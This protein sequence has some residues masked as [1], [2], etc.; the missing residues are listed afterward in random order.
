M[1]QLLLPTIIL[2]WFPLLHRRTSI[3]C[4]KALGRALSTARTRITAE[5]WQQGM[6]GAE[7]TPKHRAGEAE[8]AVKLHLPLPPCHPT[9][10]HHGWSGTNLRDTEAAAKH[11][12]QVSI[13]GLVGHA[14]HTGW[15]NKLLSTGTA[16]SQLWITPGWCTALPSS[17]SSSSQP[18]TAPVCPPHSHHQQWD[19]IWAIQHPELSGFYRRNENK[20]W[21]ARRSTASTAHVCCTDLLHFYPT[22]IC[23]GFTAIAL[24]AENQRNS[25]NVLRAPQIQSRISLCNPGILPSNSSWN[26]GMDV[27]KQARQHEARLRILKGIHETGASGAADFSSTQS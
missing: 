1:D 20:P 6:A 24:G 10:H 19:W 9:M 27:Y 5:P 16:L 17:A 22:S 14:P 26:R 12:S 23:D 7:T 25:H 8:G 4:T 11:N 15:L 13:S 2:L 3:W 21:F 18:H